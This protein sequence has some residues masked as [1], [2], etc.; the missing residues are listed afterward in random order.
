MGAG[1]PTPWPPAEHSMGSIEELSLSHSSRTAKCHQLRGRL[2]TIKVV[3]ERVYEFLL[4]LA[5]SQLSMNHKAISLPSDSS[6]ML[7]AHECYLATIPFQPM[8]PPVKSGSTK[9]GSHPGSANKSCSRAWPTPG[10]S[11]LSSLDTP[12]P[13]SSPPTD[14]LLAL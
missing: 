14:P 1:V 9:S 11:C 12:L 8:V 13:L 7:T 10:V 6:K 4:L 2:R 3:R 5:L